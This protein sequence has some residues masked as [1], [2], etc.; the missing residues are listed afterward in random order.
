VLELVP[1][2]G[3]HVPAGARLVRVHRS[4]NVDARRIQRAIIMGDERTLDDDPAF[5]VRVLVDIAV[6]ALS[7]AVN[8]PTTAVQVLDRIEDLLRFASRRQLDIGAG[9]DA[10]GALRLVFPTP[11]WRDLLDLSL[12]EIR[13]YGIGSPQVLR[14]MRALL[15]RLVEYSPERRHADVEA[16]LRL[17]EQAVERAYPAEE[18]E[19]LSVADPQGLGTTRRGYLG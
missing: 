12:T 16:H 15:V 10:E 9:R 2:I 11:S 4:T 3:D 1:A 6:R 13:I 7:P 17:L 14:R 5:A 8:D 18:H 19:L